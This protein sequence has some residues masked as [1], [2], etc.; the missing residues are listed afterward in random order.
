M[1][2]RVDCMYLDRIYSSFLDNLKILDFIG[3]Y[4]GKIKILNFGGQNRYISKIRGGHFVERSI[5]RRLAF[6]GCVLL[7]K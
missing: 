4:F 6:F 3:N 1:L 5:L 2:E 7:Q